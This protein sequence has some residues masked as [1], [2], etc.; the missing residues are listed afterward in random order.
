MGG[1]FLPRVKGLKQQSFKITHQMCTLLS[2]SMWY[3]FKNVLIGL[4][5]IDSV[6]YPKNH[7]IR[8]AE[9][10]LWPS[11]CLEFGLSGGRKILENILENSQ[12]SGQ[13]FSQLRKEE[14]DHV[15]RLDRLPHARVRTTLAVNRR[16]TLP[17]MRTMT[18]TMRHACARQ[19]ATGHQSQLWVFRAFSLDWLINELIPNCY[20]QNVNW[21]MN[22]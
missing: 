14:R 15:W 5:Q 16:G 13:E 6:V 12:E 20:S 1:I 22:F 2:Y 7:C 18:Q 10:C 17:R 9:S 8:G 21:A 4:L 11:F 3:N 19:T